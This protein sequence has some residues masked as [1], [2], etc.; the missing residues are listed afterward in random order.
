MMISLE[1]RTLPSKAALLAPAARQVTHRRAIIRHNALSYLAR[2]LSRVCNRCEHQGCSLEVNVWVFGC[3]NT[4][5][6]E[7]T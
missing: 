7:G 6:R 5:N 1:K 3:L 4:Q 2:K